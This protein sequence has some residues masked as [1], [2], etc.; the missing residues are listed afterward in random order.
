MTEQN[1]DVVVIG[2]GP[3]GLAAA[4]AAREQGIASLLV[5]EREKEPGGILRQCIHNGFGLHRFKEELTGPEYAQRDI[6]RAQ[7]LGI[8]IEC[9]TTVLAVRNSY[10]MRH[11]RTGCFTGSYHY[12][13]LSSFRIQDNIRKGCCPCHGMP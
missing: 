8:H 2:A 13:C 4:I 10:R 6:D 12:L 9:G 11:N 5:L 7:E 3:A 1:V